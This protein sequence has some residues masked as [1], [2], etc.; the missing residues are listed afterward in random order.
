[1][2]D[3]T[4]MTKFKTAK[5][6]IDYLNKTYFSI[7]KEYESY[8][9]ISY[10]GDHSVDIKK[11]KALKKRD[12]FCSDLTLSEQVKFFLKHSNGIEIEKLLHW[13]RFFDLNQTPKH[14]LSLKERISKLE[15]K[16]QKVQATQ[17]SGYIDPYTKKF[18]KMSGTSMRSLM[19]NSPDEAIRKACFEGKEKLVFKTLKDYVKFVGMLNQYAKAMGYEDFYAYK[20]FTEEGMTKKE[21]FSIF[22][23]IH[24]KT[25]YAFLDIREKE[26]S[27]PGLRKPWNF[28]HMLAGDFRKEEDQYFPFDEALSRWGQS[29]AALG[30]DFRGSTINLD[31]MEREGKF[32]NGFCHWPEIVRYEGKKRISGI[33]NF[34]C[35]VVYGEVGSAQEGYN[36]LF[37]EGGHAAHYLNSDQT[38]VCLNTEYPPASTAW[39]ETQSMFMDTLFSSYEWKSRYAKNKAGKTYP[40]DL[41]KRI[42]E[43]LHFIRPLDLSSI[44]FIADFERAIYS[45]KKLTEEKVL[46]IAKAKYKKFFDRSADSLTALSPIHI[47][48]WGS[49][50][51]YHGY[52]L[53]ELAVAQWRDYFFQKYGYIV[54]NKQVGKEMAVVWKLASAKSFKEYVL[55]ATGK[56]LSP[57]A[58]IRDVTMKP[59]QIFARSKARIKK[60]EKVPRSKGTID[61]HAKVVM[62]SGK[63]KIADNSKSFEDMAEVYAQWL[64][65]SGTI[66]K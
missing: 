49:A 3:N 47:Y 43:R 25:K 41:Y 45:E 35:N 26:K 15:T 50:C 36:T 63:K 7:H 19:V 22:D 16:M 64:P 17:K 38:E 55:M 20:I 66:K 59:A 27:M 13:K 58:F 31:L 24:K 54:D 14:L 8:Y 11:D 37:H 42:V 23:E 2:P 9:W 28:A 29:F 30:V 61:L 5:E 60:L 52:G 33:S 6:L 1:M 12:A 32:H 34:T 53:A 40:F 10:M 57:E 39:A 51:S 62:V 44:M 4:Q 18:V 48:A 21:L 56:K 65:Q 46:K